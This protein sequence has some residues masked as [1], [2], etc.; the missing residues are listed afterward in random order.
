MV[1]N[2]EWSVGAIR[3]SPWRVANG[4]WRVADGEWRM[5]QYAARGSVCDGYGGVQANLNAF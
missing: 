2:G 4:E 3:E 5:M 1:A